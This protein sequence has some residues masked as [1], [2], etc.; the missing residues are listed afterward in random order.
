MATAR[1]WA[2]GAAPRGRAVSARLSQPSAVPMGLVS[3]FSSTFCPSKCERSRYGEAAAE[4]AGWI[5]EGRIRTKEHVV[6]GGI[7]DFPETLQML[8]RGD[9]VGKLV[10]RDIITLFVAIYNGQEIFRA[11]FFAAIAANPFVSFTTIAMDSGKI[12]FKWTG[13]NGFSQT[14]SANITVE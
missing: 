13:D 10:P 7:D 4:I 6:T 11:D 3:P 8:F 14:E 5:G 12:E 9:N 2:C 1:S